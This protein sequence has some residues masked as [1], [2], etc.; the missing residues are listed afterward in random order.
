MKVSATWEARKSRLGTA[1]DRALGAEW[2]CS[3]QRV[4]QMRVHFN[5]PRFT[6]VVDWGPI[7][8]ILGT[9]TDVLIWE[10]SGVSAGCIRA[11]RKTLGIPTFRR[12]AN[13]NHGKGDYDAMVLSVVSTGSTSGTTPA[14]YQ[15]AKRYADRNPGTT[16]PL[17]L[18]R[19]VAG[20]QKA[21]LL[22]MV[23]AKT[24]QEVADQLGY[25]TGSSASAAAYAYARK[26][27]IIRPNRSNRRG[28][29]R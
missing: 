29:G 1:S 11:R 6:P 20:P 16:W 28:V 12:R 21:Y 22:F 3:R 8:P 23:T 19:R 2:G 18:T 15:R 14:Q 5:V 27:G 9:M 25:K 24:W 7:D 26:E 13:P 17:I 10:I 4:H